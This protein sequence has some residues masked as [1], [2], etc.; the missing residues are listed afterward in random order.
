M[1]TYIRAHIEGGC[2]FFTVNLA[3]Q[4]G[5]DFLIRRIEILRTAFR[6]TRKDHPFTV[7]AIVVLPYHLHCLWQLRNSDKDF[8]L[9]WRL[10]KSHLSR[11][12]EA[13]E[14]VSASH[15]RKGER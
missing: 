1:R 13:G 9:Y 12:T 11:H 6:E 3:K 7:N 14:R 8:S 5:N 10:I 15:V 2:Y 4:R